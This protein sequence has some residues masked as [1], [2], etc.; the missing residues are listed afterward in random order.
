LFSH[1]LLEQVSPTKPGRAEEPSDTG[2]EDEE[3][4]EVEAAL[5]GGLDPRSDLATCPLDGCTF[6]AIDFGGAQLAGANMR[7]ADLD[8]CGLDGAV[9]AGTGS[10]RGIRAPRNSFRGPRKFV[11]YLLLLFE[12][13]QEL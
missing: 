8:G 9:L 6:H 4:D 11:Y 10:V 2:E 5:F 13:F 7:G 12:L 1:A 3:D